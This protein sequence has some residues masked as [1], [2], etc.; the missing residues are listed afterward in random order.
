MS[1]HDKY[2]IVFHLATAVFF[3]TA[4]YFSYLNYKKTQQDSSIWLIFFIGSLLG[5]IWG[6]TGSPLITKPIHDFSFA[7]I[8]LF[9]TTFA[10][11]SY[12]HFLKPYEKL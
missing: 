7:V 9:F 11:V 10:A 3:L 2:I 4:G 8:I 6:V 12:L 5:F 1:F